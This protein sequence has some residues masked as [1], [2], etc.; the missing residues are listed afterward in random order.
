MFYV[1]ILNVVDGT[2]MLEG[3]KDLHLTLEGDLDGT[4]LFE[5]IC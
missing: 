4:D 2:G 3:C 5:K 1:N